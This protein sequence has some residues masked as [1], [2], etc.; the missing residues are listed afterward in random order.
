MHN[1]LLLGD[2]INLFS[3]SD[4]SQDNILSAGPTNNSHVLSLMLVN[5]ST[6][7][8][9]NKKGVVAKHYSRASD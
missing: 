1:L 8:L 7:R 2:V 9:T 4:R 5:S 3:S 6:Q